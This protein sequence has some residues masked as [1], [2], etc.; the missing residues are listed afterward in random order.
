MTI[1]SK[2]PDVG[3][4]IFT[5]MS[6]PAHEQGAITLSQGFPDFDVSSELVKKV[7][8]LMRAGHNQNSPMKGIH[9]LR[10]AGEKSCTI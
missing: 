5:V 4:T 3:V 2:L 6:Q 7:S 9:A 1:E 8:R 10:E